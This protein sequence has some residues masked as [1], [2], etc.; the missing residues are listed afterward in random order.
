MGEQLDYSIKLL[1][2][3]EDGCRYEVSVT[4]PMSYGWLEDLYYCVSSDKFNYCFKIAFDHNDE[5]NVHFKGEVYLDTRA[6][7]RTHF[8]FTANGKR[9]FLNKNKEAVEFLDNNTLDKISVNF[10]T[11]EWAKGAM[12]YH[13]FVDS[14]YRANKEPIK[15]IRDRRV[16]ESWDEKPLDGPD[17]KNIWCNDYYGGDLLGIV[18]KMDYIKS[19]GTDILYLSPIVNGQSNHRYDASDFELVDPYLGD[20]EDLITLCDEA[21]KRGMKVILDGV[22]NHTGSDSKYFN[23][24][25]TFPD[26]GA[27]Q[28]IMSLYG[29]FYKKSYGDDGRLYFHHWWGMP[30]LPRC[31]SYS[32]T[33]QDYIYGEGGIVDRWFKMGI[34]GLRLDVADELSDEF[35]EGIRKAVSRHK[36]DGLIIG[37]VWKNAMRMNREYISSGKAMDSHMNYPLVDALMRYLKYTDVHKLNYI[38]HDMLNE[39]PKGTIDTMMNFTSTHDISRPIDIFG[40]KEFDFY[41]E[42]AWNTLHSRENETDYAYYNNFKMTPE[43]IKKGK[44]IFKTYLFCLNFM[45]GIL[46]VFYGDE[47]G[48]L[49]LGNILNRA[50]YP[51]GKEDQDLVG[52]VKTLGAI[53]KEEQFLRTADMNIVDITPDYFM[54]ERNSGE[55]DALITINRTPEKKK[56]EI[57]SKYESPNTIYT[58]NKSHKKILT[59]YGGNAIIKH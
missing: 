46:S 4:I 7:Y 24:K 31:D 26:K 48:M 28:D 54:F 15:S 2:K 29:S 37:E 18:E 49:G 43:E 11:P 40:T 5:K 10:D 47:A 1:E 8:T 38:I 23:E 57:P 51:W 30:T 59:P 36:K 9:L 32:K 39:Y 25:G 56:I 19:L 12:M 17:D 33:W 44:E 34:D 21:H 42:W 20:N 50:S 55:G 22:F 53:R 6:I 27:C 14:F 41:T 58:L 13:I 35:I 52:F 16:H 45:P 3:L